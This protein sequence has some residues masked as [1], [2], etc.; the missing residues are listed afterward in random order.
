ML[1]VDVDGDAD[2]DSDGGFEVEGFR[3]VSLYESVGSNTRPLIEVVFSTARPQTAVHIPVE[4]VP[5]HPA[6]SSHH[7]ASLDLD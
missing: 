3:Y 2:S 4:L 7:S 5:V 1:V 6:L